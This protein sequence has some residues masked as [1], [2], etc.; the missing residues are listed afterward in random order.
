[1][2]FMKFL[3]GAGLAAML[4]ACGGGGGVGDSAG[5]GSGGGT[6]GGSSTAPVI[7]L[8]VLS[9]AGIVTNSISSV[10]IGV[11][12]ATL[13][14]SKGAP[15][16]GAIVTFAES[17]AGLLTIAPTSGTALTDA[18]GR[19]F[20]EVRAAS[21]SST[22][23]TLVTAAATV[24]TQAATVQNAIAVTNAP[25]TGGPDPQ[26]LANALNFLDTNPADKSI[27]L[28][29][30]GGNGRSESATLRF[31]VVDKNNSPVKG[32]SVNFEAVPKNDVTLN[33]PTAISDTD[34]VVVTTVASKNVATAVVVK[35][36]VKTTDGKMITSQSDQLL[37][38]TNIATQRGFDL[39]ASKY[40][41]NST[42]TGDSSNI[43]VS[44]V[45]V[46]GNRVAD[47]VPVV[48]TTD[49]GAVATSSRG[50]CTTLN[51]AC[52]VLYTVQNPRPEDGELITVIA[53]TQVGTGVSVGGSIVLSAVAPVNL[54]IFDDASAADGDIVPSFD[55]TNG[56]RTCKR[57]FTTFVGT[58]AAFPAPAGTLV[59]TKVLGSGV[60]ASILLGSPIVDQLGRN[61]LRTRL[62]IEVEASADSG[63]DVTGSGVGTIDLEV[64]F[65]SSTISSSR[66]V[67]VRYPIQ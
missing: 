36:T 32:V 24:A 46:N 16:S 11:A 22:G 29:G 40:N 37:V 13:K 28:A 55:L 1:M 27:V 53:S 62:V 49:F 43:T 58:P 59:E 15:V 19:A 9:G 47:G 34:G 20:V 63:C 60:S 33:I 6:G 25:S 52:T 12:R 14:D 17:G 10:E 38:T 64:K 4:A 51:G 31:R 39:S 42:I 61:K 57:S 30:S 65:T 3:A 18:N 41:L 35:A 50:G 67:G 44:I 23:A 5:G 26:T 2:R 48:F 8:E 7:T 21:V 45:D 54:N 66:I 56:T